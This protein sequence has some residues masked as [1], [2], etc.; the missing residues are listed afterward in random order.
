MVVERYL[1]NISFQRDAKT[2]PQIFGIYRSFPLE[3]AIGS[4]G[5]DVKNA[6]LCSKIKV[7][8]YRSFSLEL[9]VG[10][11]GFDVKNADL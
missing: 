6:D 3:L 9:A 5:F 7:R 1:Y 2:T 8:I 11:H 10:S 4:Y